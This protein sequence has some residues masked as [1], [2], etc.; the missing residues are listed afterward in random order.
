MTWYCSGIVYIFTRIYTDCSTYGLTK[1]FM[2]VCVKNCAIDLKKNNLYW[3]LI[4][5]VIFNSIIHEFYWSRKFLYGT[6]K[7]KP[8]EYIIMPLVFYVTQAYLNR[9]LLYCWLCRDSKTEFEIQI[10]QKCVQHTPNKPLYTTIGNSR[11]CPYNF[12][13]FF[14]L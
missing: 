12:E 3:I 5:F 1:Q 8:L 13:R 7:T 10:W 4:E 6:S 14:S 9:S 2:Y 11:Y